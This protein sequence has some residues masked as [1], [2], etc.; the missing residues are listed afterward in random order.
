MD[1]IVS[2]SRFAPRSRSGK[3]ANLSGAAGGGAADGRKGSSPIESGGDVGSVE[4]P[5]SFA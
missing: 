3:I 2:L 1:F 4:L 5:N